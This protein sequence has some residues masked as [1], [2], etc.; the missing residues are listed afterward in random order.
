VVVKT[1]KRREA[2]KGEERDGRGVQFACQN[3][4][5]SNSIISFIYN[6]LLAFYGKIG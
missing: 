3:L 2:E 5:L 6:N 4:T 1:G